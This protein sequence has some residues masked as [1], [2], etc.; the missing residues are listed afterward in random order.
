[1]TVVKL[2]QEER[3]AIAWLAAGQ[4]VEWPEGGEGRRMRARLKRLGLIKYVNRRWKATRAGCDAATIRAANE[5]AA[6][7]AVAGVSD[8]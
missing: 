3:Y 7:E 5:Q 4:L 8:V 6:Q 1:M 2:T